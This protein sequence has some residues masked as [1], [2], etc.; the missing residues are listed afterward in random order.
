MGL[1]DPQPKQQICVMLR[2]LQTPNL[3]YR[4]T[5]FSRFKNSLDLHQSQELPMAKVG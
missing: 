3:I 5:S 2:I 1:F 4:L